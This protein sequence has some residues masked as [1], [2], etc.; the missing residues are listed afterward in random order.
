MGERLKAAIAPR[1]QAWLARETGISTSMVGEYVR[2]AVPAADRVLK[3]ARA[4]G[5]SLEW[6]IDGSG[7]KR[8]NNLALADETDW[9]F[10]PRFDVNKMVLKGARPEPEEIM[11][12]RRDLI[13]AHVS[14]FK[15]LWIT[16]MIGGALPTV[17]GPDEMILCRD[18]VDQLEDGRPYIISWGDGLACRRA[19]LKPDG[20]HFR[21]DDPNYEEIFVAPTEAR[22]VW[23]IGRILGSLALR[24]AP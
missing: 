6:L 3:I 10:V 7:P 18:V 13:A 23:P 11:P 17:A 16:R 5:V 21:T 22:Q 19:Y 8:R 24:P 1:D 20:V 15:D 12:L 14:N 2:G 4:L 9:L